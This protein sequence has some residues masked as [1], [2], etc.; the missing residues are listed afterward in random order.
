MPK[1]TDLAPVKEQLEDALTTH[2]ARGMSVVRACNRVAADYGA[3]LDEVEAALRVVL[4]EARTSLSD[5]AILDVVVSQNVN[6]LQRMFR[7]FSRGALAPVQED[8]LDSVKTQQRSAKREDARIA[9]D[10]HKTLVETLGVRN[11]DYSPKSQNKVTV[12]IQGDAENKRAVE[13]LL[14]MRAPETATVDA[15]EVPDDERV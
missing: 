4:E 13:V 3:P 11:Q 2:L 15:E 1:M 10:L 14:G 7:T 9:K 5:T 6:T 8:V 12:D